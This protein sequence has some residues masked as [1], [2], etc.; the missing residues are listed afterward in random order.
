MAVKRPADNGDGPSLF[1][2]IPAPQPLAPVSARAV[3]NGVVTTTQVDR[4]GDDL[5]VM[6]HGSRPMRFTPCPSP[7]TARRAL[8]RYHELF[9]EEYA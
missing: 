1:G 5:I 3:A 8:F 2:V 7:V 4:D 6:I 9:Y